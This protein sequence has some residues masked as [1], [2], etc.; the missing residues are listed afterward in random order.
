M[1]KQYQKSH[2][3]AKF[4]EFR[5]LM[6]EYHDGILLF[7]LTDKVVW[8][9]AATDTAG[10]EAYYRKNMKKYMWGERLDVAIYT[11]KDSASAKKALKLAP[12]REKKKLSHDWLASRVCPEDTTRSCVLIEELKV[13]K[14]D[15]PVVEKAGWSTGISGFIPYNGKVVFVVK[16]KIVPPE[17]KT[18]QEAR[19]LVIADYQDELEKRWIEDLRAKYKVEIDEQVLSRVK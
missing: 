14:G 7:D 2:L 10:L 5:Y 18:L 9:R 17:Q 8:S 6:Q 15:H 1:L 12:Q 13:E 4:P 11:C 3:E 19:G 16:R